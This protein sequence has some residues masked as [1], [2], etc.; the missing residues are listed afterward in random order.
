MPI[1]I[2]IINSIILL[3]SHNVTCFGCCIPMRHRV[4]NRAPQPPLK[5]MTPSFIQILLLNLQTVQA[6][7][8]IKSATPP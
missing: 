4:K 1:I 5:Y 3:V 2:T 7:F 8:H 6:N